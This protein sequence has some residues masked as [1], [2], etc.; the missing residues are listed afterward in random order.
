MTFSLCLVKETKLQQKE[1]SMTIEEAQTINNLNY[2]CPGLS[3]VQKELPL[4]IQAVR[5]EMHDNDRLYLSLFKASDERVV[6]AMAAAEKAMQT[7]LA[8]T[9]EA[10][11]K[12]ALATDKRFDE[13]SDKLDLLRESLSKQITTATAASA[14]TAGRSGG[15]NAMWGYVVGVV[16][17]IGMIIAIFLNI[18]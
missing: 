5:V 3:I 2:C 15:L 18:T 4:L 6:V 9:K 13:V 12:A 7:A 14:L 16:G 11:D 8:V 17:L 10:A 1:V